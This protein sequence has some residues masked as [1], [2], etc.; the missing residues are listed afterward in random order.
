MCSRA[1]A[2]AVALV[3]VLP[4]GGCY[5]AYENTVS[6]QGPTGNGVD[7]SVGPL[8][9]QDTTLVAG[10]D[11]R[12]ASL[13]FV[14]VNDSDEADYLTA[15]SVNG[16]AASVAGAPLSIPA[17]SSVPVGGPAPAQVT[18]AGLTV[19]AGDYTSV[20]IAFRNSGSVTAEI[21]VVPAEGYYSSYGPKP[22]M[23]PV[24][25]PSAPAASEQAASEPAASPAP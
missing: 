19:P 2:A 3:A 16:A 4:L 9:V 20:T 6:V 13:I 1:A 15:A 23:A 11:G 7:V 18:V 22:A 24:P 25:A 14:V 21:P 5:Q 8:L 12:A 10:A 17:R